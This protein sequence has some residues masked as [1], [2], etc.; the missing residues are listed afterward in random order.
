MTL[1]NVNDDKEVGDLLLE[2]MGTLLKVHQF[3]F[4]KIH[5]Y[6]DPKEVILDY[7]K[8]NDLDLIVFGA[9]G[10]DKITRFLFCDTTKVILQSSGL[11]L[12]LDH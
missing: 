9:Y 11:P 12:F 2:R 10:R 1:L 8:E 3:D 5:V 7:S 6:G 4:D